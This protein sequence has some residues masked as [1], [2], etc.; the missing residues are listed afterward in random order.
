LLSEKLGYRSPR[1]EYGFKRWYPEQGLTTYEYAQTI[2][3]WNRT[4]LQIARKFDLNKPRA[5]QLMRGNQC[6]TRERP[7]A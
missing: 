6:C 1:K 7:S 3:R 5:R 4:L 2:E